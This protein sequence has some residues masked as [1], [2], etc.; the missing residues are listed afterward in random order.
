[1][2][3][4]KIEELDPKVSVI[5]TTYNRAKLLINRS[6][7]SALNQDFNDFEVLIID[8]C[9]QDDTEKE[10]EKII[11][12]YKNL[13]YIRQE[14]NKGISVSKNKG[15]LESRGKYIVFLDDDNE[16]FKDFLK[17]TVSKLDNLEN[18][19]GAICVG[20]VISHYGKIEEYT[21]SN[22]KNSFY[23]SID[24]GWLMRR[25][26]Y[27][28]IS[29]DE[30]LRADEDADFGI[31]FF[32]HYK[33]YFINQVLT[34]AYIYKA[35]KGIEKSI[36]LPSKERNKSLT[37]FL[38]KNLQIFKEKGSKKDLS[39]IYRFAGTNYYLGEDKKKE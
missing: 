15:I 21:S 10:V 32:K 22:L 3:N 26:I 37:I 13:K 4:S 1:M 29:Y 7:P 17:A 39:F 19:Y 11:K 16:L 24:W 35:E 25:E 23:A 33:A 14:K 27:N 18:D 31:Q 34:K 5:I 2:Q 20:R 30:R 36:S 9:S 12:K 6:L 8:D 28:K 38:E